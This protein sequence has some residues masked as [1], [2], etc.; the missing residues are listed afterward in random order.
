M[1]G[2]VRILVDEYLLYVRR[3]ANGY[4][5]GW[6]IDGWMDIYVGGRIPT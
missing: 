5:N 2:Y 4:L 3:W 6:W 1:D